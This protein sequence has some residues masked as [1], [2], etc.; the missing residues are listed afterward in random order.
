MC[1]SFHLE[2]LLNLLCPAKAMFLAELCNPI[3]RQAIELFKPST[4]SASLVV[5]IEKKIFSFLVGVFRW[6]R[7]KWGCFWL[8]LPGPWPY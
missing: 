8:P 3:T 7:H 2:K 5:K 1:K 6:E 4:D